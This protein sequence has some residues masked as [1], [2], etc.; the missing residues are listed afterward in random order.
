MKVRT[1]QRGKT[2]HIY[3]NLLLSVLLLISSIPLWPVSKV[4]AADEEHHL[5]SLNRPV[6]SSSSLGAIRQIMW[7]T[8]TKTAAGKAYGSKIRNGSMLT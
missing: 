3:I 1:S 6:Y 4:N 8:A 2:R 7:L 5:L